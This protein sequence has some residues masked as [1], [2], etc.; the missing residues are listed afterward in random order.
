MSYFERVA[1]TLLDALLND[2]KPVSPF[3]IFKFEIYQKKSLSVPG[4]DLCGKFSS[5]LSIEWFQ[6]QRRGYGRGRSHFTLLSWNIP[7]I[8]WS[9]TR[10]KM[11]WTLLQEQWPAHSFFQTL[12]DHQQYCRLVTRDTPT[13]NQILFPRS[14]GE[15]RAISNSEVCTVVSQGPPEHLLLRVWS[16]NYPP[17]HHVGTRQKH[18]PPALPH[19]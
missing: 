17:L 8:S 7:K 13:V 6:E 14:E 12:T 4:S 18:R 19:T 10:I 2:R 11:M 16:T 15:R 1:E 9:A 5:S 3:H